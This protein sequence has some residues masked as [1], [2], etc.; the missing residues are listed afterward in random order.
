LMLRRR[1]VGPGPAPDS[2]ATVQSRTS[3]SPY[4]FER[5]SPTIR[6]PSGGGVEKQVAVGGM[7]TCQT[8]PSVP[9]SY[10]VTL[11]GV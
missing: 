8:G 3:F 5:S 1:F 2:G 10:P 9:R 6:I 4:G 11:D 7:R